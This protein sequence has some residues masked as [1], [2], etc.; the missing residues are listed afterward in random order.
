VTLVDADGTRAN[1]AWFGQLLGNHVLTLPLASP[2][3]FEAIGTTAG[4]DLAAIDHMHLQLDPGGFGN[5]GAYTVSWNELS[6][7]TVAGVTGD[8]DDDGDVDGQDFLAW[9][10]GLSP[11]SLSPID[12]AD[13]QGAYGGGPLAAVSSVPEPSSICLVVLLS[14]SAFGRFRPPRSMA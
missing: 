9:Q 14:V 13:W 6:L 2:S 1:Y 12:L 10:R 11:S 4:L 3:W 7:I 8:F 5:A